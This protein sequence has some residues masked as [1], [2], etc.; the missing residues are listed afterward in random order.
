MKLH[1]STSWACP[2]FG[3][4]THCLPQCSALSPK[5]RWWFYL[6]AIIPAHLAAMSSYNLGLWWLAYQI[7]FNS[8]LTATYAA[9]L[10]RF[11]PEILYFETLLRR[12]YLSGSISRC[13]GFENWAAIYPVFK[14]SPSS[15]ALLAHNSSDGFFA[16][17]SAVGSI[18]AASFIAF[19]PAILGLRYARQLLVS[20]FLLTTSC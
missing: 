5:G 16:V 17:T 2:R 1:F 18:T 19:V 11:K 12:S 7:A 8:A 14:F 20:R 13:S 15:S 6:F 9:I 10:Q 4:Q 3:S